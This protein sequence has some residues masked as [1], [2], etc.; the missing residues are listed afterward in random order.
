MGEL[1]KTLS[2]LPIVLLAALYCGYLAY[3]YYDWLNS[4]QS[5]LGKKKAAV[6]AAKTEL[7]AAKKKLASGQE[8]FRNLDA[9]R[10]R[11]RSLTSQLEG[12]KATLSADID[13]A[14]FLRMITLE[15]KKLGLSIKGVK[16]DR[17]IKQEYYLEVPFTVAFKGAYVQALVFF[18]R[19]SKFQQ[20]IRVSDF[21]L[22]PTG[23]VFTKYVELDGSV[24]LIAYKY[25]GTAVD[26]V[27]DKKEMNDEAEKKLI[28][29]FGDKGEKKEGK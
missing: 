8:F 23:N 7:D 15:A 18:D 3:D 4:P 28:N 26:D 21:D 1:N 25:L 19:I 29:S 27:K 11:I 12:S 14:N 10:S 9:L 2:R 5:E 13:I 6:V 16:P 24:K 22:K 20:V 17:E